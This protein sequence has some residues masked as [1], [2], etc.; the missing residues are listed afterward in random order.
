[1]VDPSLPAEQAGSYAVAGLVAL[2]ILVNLGNL[3]VRRGGVSMEK[4]CSR[5]TDASKR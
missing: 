1:M 3:A 4:T 5:G 2:F